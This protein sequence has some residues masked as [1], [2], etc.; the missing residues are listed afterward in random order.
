MF[1]TES[2]V[3]SRKG[4]RGTSRFDYLQQ[5]VTE[6]QDTTKQESKRQII[7]NLA[8][9][10]YD[11]YNYAILNE[12]NILDLF[13]DGLGDEDELI[14]E[15]AIG[16]ICNC[17]CYPAFLDILLSEKGNIKS[18][19]HLLS[20]TNENILISSMATL[21]YLIDTPLGLKLLAKPSVK[22]ALSTYANCENVK[23]AN[24]ASCMLSH[25]ENL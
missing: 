15:F 16:G 8:N 7:A 19:I 17:I 24:I 18:I 2:Y 5:L 6:Y 1:A 21:Y 11:P 9:F 10:A 23:I 20:S 25:L 13:L 14:V 22:T 3:Q 4:D 12:L